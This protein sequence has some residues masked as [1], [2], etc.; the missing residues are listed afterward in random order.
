M[1]TGVRHTSRVVEESFCKNIEKAYFTEVGDYKI[2]SPTLTPVL[3]SKSQTGPTKTP[4]LIDSTIF[5]NAPKYKLSLKTMTQSQNYLTTRYIGRAPLK[6]YGAATEPGTQFI[7]ICKNGNPSY[8]TRWFGT[9]DAIRGFNRNANDS[10]IYS[11]S[12]T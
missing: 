10:F 3:N 12:T 11:K 9:E 6:F 2:Y 8:K 4:V 5:K 7:L 1:I